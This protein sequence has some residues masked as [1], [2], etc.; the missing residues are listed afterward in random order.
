M[1][2]EA[3]EVIERLNQMGID[4]IP[5]NI[6]D[7]FYEDGYVPEG[8]KQE[9][10]AYIE[11]SKISEDDKELLMEAF[12]GYLILHFTSELAGVTVGY[13]GDEIYF[14]NLTHKKLDAIMD[15]FDEVELTFGG[16]PYSIYSES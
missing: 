9:T 5:L 14:T 15:R 10:H 1:I 7:D 4:S 6:W 12:H 3:Q 11:S 8:K 13:G 2:K 16:I